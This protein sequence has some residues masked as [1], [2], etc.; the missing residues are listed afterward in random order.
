MYNEINDYIV[1]LM[2]SAECVLQA[3]HTRDEAVYYIDDE[4]DNMMIMM[5]I[6]T[7]LILMICV[8]YYNLYNDIHNYITTPLFSVD[9]CVLQAHTG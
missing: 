2:F 6:M 1:I 9:E 3:R 5:A 4:N 7:I 8:T